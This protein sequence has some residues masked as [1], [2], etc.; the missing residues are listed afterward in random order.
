M[1]IGIDIGGSHIAVGLVNEN[2]QIVVKKEYEWTVE[3][4]NNLFSNIESY[5]KKLINEIIEENNIKTIELIGIGYPYKNIVNGIIY[6]D[7]NELNLP[8]IL[9]KEF[10]VPVYLKNDVKCSA[11]CEKTLGNLKE[12]QNCIFI[13]LGTGIGGAYFYNNELLTP[14]KY[15]GLEIGHMIIEKNGKQCRCGQKGCFEEY[16]SM[17]VFRNEISE[18]FNLEKVNSFKVFEIIESKEKQEE[19]NKIIEKYTD[20]LAIGLSNLI[21]IFEPDAICIGGSFTYYAPIFMDK[22]KQKIQENFKE[23]EIPKII[24]AKFENDA[25]IIGAAMLQS[26]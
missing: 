6:K 4:R 10:N 22:I 20:Y 2:M 25:G 15:Q 17:R 23:R 11:M 5:T 12:Y 1:K 8:E 21:N 19:V 18:L 16:A 14:S 24:T 9:S 13:T 26:N 7:G 3:E